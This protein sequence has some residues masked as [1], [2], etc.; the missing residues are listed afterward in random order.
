M[1]NNAIVVKDLNKKFKSGYGI[2]DINFNVKYGKVFGYLGPNGAGKSTTIRSLM[3]FIKSDSGTSNVYLENKPNLKND[4]SLITELIQFDSWTDANKIQR[5]L[6]YVPGE[7]AFPIQMTGIDLLKQ[8]FKLRN[9][10]NWDDVRKYI[11]YWEFNPNMKIKKMSK[12][13]KQKVALVIAWMHNPDIIVLDEPTSGLDPL[14]QEKFV[15]LVQKSKEEGKAIIL[16]SHIFS[17]IERT[18]DYVSIIKRGKIISTINIED[19]QYNDE[20]TYEIKFKDKVTQKDVESKNWTIKSFN[21]NTLFAVVENKNINDFIVKMSK[22]KLEFI[23]EHPLN[24]EQYFMKYYQNEIETDVIESLD[25]INVNVST[26]ERKISFELIKDTMRKTLGLWLFTTILPVILIIVAFAVMINDSSVNEMIIQGST[27]SE[28]LTGATVALVVSSTGI[29]YSLLLVYLLTSGNN[30][31]ASE[32]DKGTMV[33]LLTTNQSRKSVILT[34]G[35]TFVFSLF[36]SIFIQ[37][38]TTIITISVFGK[39]GE[40]NIGLFAMYFFGLFL[41][42]YA[43]SSIAF[44]CSCYFNKSAASLS[45]AGGISIIFYVLFFASQIPS[46]EFLK[47]FSLNS[48]FTVEF[49]NVSEISKYLG[50]YIALGVIGTGLYIASYWIFIK[51]DLPL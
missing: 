33:N 27:W 14:M 44:I 41:M 12:G 11:D 17:E 42:L 47:Y 15:K 48:L 35:G 6:G 30:I 37:F 28:V 34:K 25:N 50:Q 31:V 26:K 9:M 4:Q 39:G 20:K 45:T 5:N 18:C 38:L 46:V 22:N 36:I 43:I 51:K 19:I 1:S 32:V 24:L 8:V 16:S 23:K 49:N 40:I 3:G 13:M 10:T 21:N 7:I 2:F 29:T